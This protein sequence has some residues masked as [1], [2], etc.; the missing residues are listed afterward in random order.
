MFFNI[1]TDDR[2]DHHLHMKTLVQNKDEICA[3]GGALSQENICQ[4]WL[5]T[6]K[7][8]V[9]LNNSCF[10]T[11]GS[12]TY[13]HKLYRIKEMY[14]YVCMYFIRHYVYFYVLLVYSRPCSRC[15]E[16]VLYDGSRQFVHFNTFAV[17]IAVLTL[18]LDSFLI[19][20]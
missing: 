3:C 17:S 10:Y 19:S 16:K 14:A 15:K 1:A 12:N 20:W 11:Q 18:Y 13:S 5:Q 8:F 7:L 4:S 6:E 9:C 2:I